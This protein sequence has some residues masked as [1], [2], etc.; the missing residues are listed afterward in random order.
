MYSDLYMR[1]VD[2]L[3][4]LALGAPAQIEYAGGFYNLP[5]ELAIDF[6]L[7]LSHMKAL[8]RNDVLSLDC[9][10]KINIIFTELSSVSYDENWSLKALSTNESWFEVRKLALDALISLNEEF[11]HPISKF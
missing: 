2:L 4:V 1:F 5:S 7:G 11:K 3:R 10:Q 8:K 9:I 6:D